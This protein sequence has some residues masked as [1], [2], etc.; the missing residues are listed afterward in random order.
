M[1]IAE[2]RKEKGLSLEAF[3]AEVGL[4]SKGQMYLIEKGAR[5]S[6]A[7]ALRI[8]RLSDG[9]I[10]AADLNATVALVEEA[11]AS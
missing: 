6:V 7:V 5:P 3:A 1:T 10:L 8:E 2:L 9:R 4:K 11:R